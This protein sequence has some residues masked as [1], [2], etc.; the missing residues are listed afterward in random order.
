MRMVD[1]PPE[2]RSEAG[3]EEKNQPIG[4]EQAIAHARILGAIRKLGKVRWGMCVSSS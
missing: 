2:Y 3:Y 4:Y 1:A